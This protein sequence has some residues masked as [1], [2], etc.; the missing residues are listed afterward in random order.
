MARRPLTPSCQS[1]RQGA[2]QD[3][4]S[5]TRPVDI[6]SSE[7]DC[8]DGSSSTSAEADDYAAAGYFANNFND[9]LGSF[10]V[11]F[12]LM[13]TN[14]WQTIVAGFVS[15]TGTRWVRAFFIVNY[16]IEVF[17]HIYMYTSARLASDLVF[18]IN[19]EVENIIADV[20]RFALHAV[21][22]M[23]VVATL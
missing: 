17:I 6:S 19:C 13:V 5:P 4:G 2:A 14:D 18:P 16:A 21:P 20:A 9:L 10:V 3:A 7:G 22:D 15:A 23:T 8:D 11:L 12:E 1:G